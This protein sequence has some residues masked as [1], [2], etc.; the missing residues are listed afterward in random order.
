MA[1]FNETQMEE[2]ETI[3]DNM[4]YKAMDEYDPWYPTKEE[5]EEHLT[6]KAKTDALFLMWLTDPAGTLTK[7]E[8]E[9]KSYATK[10]LYRPE[11]VN[12]KF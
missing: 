7:E 1:S 10:M 5:L 6:G 4:T 12:M 8:Q 3:I 2:A 11:I 9:V